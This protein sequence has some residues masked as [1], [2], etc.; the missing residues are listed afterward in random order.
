MKGI[1]LSCFVVGFLL[2]ACSR[3]DCTS[4]PTE[5]TSYE[6]ALRTIRQTEFPLSEKIKTP[7]SSWIRAAEF[8]SCDRQT[9]YF[10]LVTD[11]KD[12]IFR[13]MPMEVWDGFKR[14]ESY[15]KYYHAQIKNRYY[16]EL[17]SP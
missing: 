3:P 5:Y 13:D 10:I 9:G 2:L 15:G 11:S 7:E 17:S 14:A 6:E 16:F 1:G 8:Y 4:L 12:Y